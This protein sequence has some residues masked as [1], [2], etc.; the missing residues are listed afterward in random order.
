MLIFHIVTLVFPEA[1]LYFCRFRPGHLVFHVNQRDHA[2]KYAV[3]GQPSGRV[4]QIDVG[5][6]L[7]PGT[8]VIWDIL[9]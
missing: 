6:F 2:S 7:H 3:F 5:P 9:G 8:T 1:I 4:P